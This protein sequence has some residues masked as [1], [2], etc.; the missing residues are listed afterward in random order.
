MSMADLDKWRRP[1][2]R[3]AVAAAQARLDDTVNRAVWQTGFHVSVGS[4]VSPGTLITT[5]DDT[6]VMKST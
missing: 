3:W 5:L 6:S 4:F 2:G 1:E